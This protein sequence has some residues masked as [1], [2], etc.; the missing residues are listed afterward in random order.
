M[1]IINP[2]QEIDRLVRADA[3]VKTQTNPVARATKRGYLDYL[4][5]VEKPEWVTF[6]LDSHYNKGVRS[7]KQL[8]NALDARGLAWQETI[9][10]KIN[11]RWVWTI[12]REG[13]FL[14][15]GE[16]NSEKKAAIAAELARG[17]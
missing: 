7:A 9:I 16:A 5:G 3:I 1:K 13:F 15:S 6:E 12:Y 11:G 8:R 14:A 10:E 4:L 17:E 2:Q